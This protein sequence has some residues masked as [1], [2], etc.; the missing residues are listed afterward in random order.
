MGG[1]ESRA[2]HALHLYIYAES[3]TV[4]QVVYLTCLMGK[5]S[6]SKSIFDVPTEEILC[7]W[8]QEIQF[9][10]LLTLELPVLSDE[11]CTKSLKHFR[12]CT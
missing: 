1:L 5:E 6:I 4:P 8:V 10:D 3:G 2:V 12:L 7:H 9:Y 11:P